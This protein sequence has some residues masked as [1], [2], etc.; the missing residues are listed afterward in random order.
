MIK[1]PLKGG[2][3][4]YIGII[5]EDTSD[6]KVIVELIHK[7]CPRNYGIRQFVG[8]GCGRIVGKCRAWAEQLK[9]RGC[10]YL[11]IVQDLDRKELEDLAGELSRALNPSPISDYAI[12]IPVKE[13]EAWLLADEE[14]IVNAI[15]LRKK[16]KKISNPEA[17][18]D[19]KRKLGEIIYTYSDKKVIYINTVHNERI[20]KK[21]SIDALKRCAS[22]AAFHQFVDNVP[23]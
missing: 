3:A 21:C 16:L 9:Q 19:P 17:I 18:I 4:P 13:M 15:N 8:E 12:I 11:L 7:I 20:A 1:K 2:R 10:K 5:A 6:V 22:F 23:K 14:A